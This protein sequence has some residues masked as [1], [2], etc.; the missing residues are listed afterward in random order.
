MPAMSRQSGRGSLSNRKHRISGH[1]S[2]NSPDGAEEP[3]LA[4]ALRGFT[5]QWVA[6]RGQKV[7]ASAGTV[8]ELVNLLRDSEN[9]YN[10]E[11]VFRVPRNAKEDT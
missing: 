2:H 7:V 10:A 6:I 1:A 11:S 8:S 4:T 5:G 3:D 9:E